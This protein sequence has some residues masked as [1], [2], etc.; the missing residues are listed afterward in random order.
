MHAVHVVHTSLVALRSCA[1]SFRL[2][3][4]GGCGQSHQPGSFGEFILIGSR[5]GQESS[6]L[7]Y[8]LLVHLVFWHLVIFGSVWNLGEIIVI[9]WLYTPLSPKNCYLIGNM[10]INQWI[11]QSCSPFWSTRWRRPAVD[12]DFFNGMVL[13]WDRKIARNNAATIA[14]R[15]WW[16]FLYSESHDTCWIMLQSF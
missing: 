14:M 13:E 8:I 9:I 7:W 4:V 1:S 16:C 12:V 15:V 3:A 11:S 5:H 2:H 10:M 6:S